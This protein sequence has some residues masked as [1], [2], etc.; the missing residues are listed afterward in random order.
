MTFTEKYFLE[1]IN[2]FRGYL[3]DKA[4]WEG[5]EFT[6]EDCIKD[7]I[8]IY[9]SL[10]NED[11]S[12]ITSEQLKK[13]ATWFAEATGEYNLRWALKNPTLKF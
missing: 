3:D 9:F 10:A 13:W 5:P 4:W 1:R 11:G 6:R 12:P 2:H 7:L 8:T